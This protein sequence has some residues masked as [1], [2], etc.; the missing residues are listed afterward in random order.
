MPKNKKQVWRKISSLKFKNNLEK[1]SF[2][3]IDANLSKDLNFLKSLIDLKSLKELDLLEIVVGIE[4]ISYLSR[5]LENDS[6]LIS[7]SINGLILMFF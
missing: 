7:L 5:A 3:C 1:I 2:G 4:F 6:N